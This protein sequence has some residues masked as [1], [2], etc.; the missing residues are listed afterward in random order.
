MFLFA[1]LWVSNRETGKTRRFT[2]MTLSR[3]TATRVE[4]I[5]RTEKNP[6]AGTLKN[7]NDKYFSQGYGQCKVVFRTLKKDDRIQPCKSDLDF[8]HLLM[9]L[10]LAK[11]CFFHYTTSKNIHNSQTN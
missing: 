2:R 11:I 10:M 7:Y 5:I 8:R 9:V 6:D 1:I 3:P 4:C